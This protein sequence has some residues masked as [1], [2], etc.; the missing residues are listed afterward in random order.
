MSEQG[1]SN[2]QAFGAGIAA[3]IVVV[4]VGWKALN[5]HGNRSAPVGAVP[6]AAPVDLTTRDLVPAPTPVPVAAPEDASAA[7]APVAPGPVL[8]PEKTSSSAVRP[9]L[10]E[11]AEAKLTAKLS[12]EKTA[13]FTTARAEVK[14]AS[15]AP[16]AVAA[17]AAAPKPKL[18]ETKAAQSVASAV[19]YS[20]TSRAE[21]MGRAAGPVYNLQ[22]GGV[23]A[24]NQ[25]G[26]MDAAQTADQSVA[27]AR[28]VIEQSN[29]TVEEKT[30]AL[31][32]IDAAV[33][34]A[35]ANAAK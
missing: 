23:Q 18:D 30:K 22:A 16:V 10:R 31:A 32:Q 7:E 8:A 11:S 14:P 9:A 12:E 24:Q 6:A 5:W 13:A 3:F 19:Q 21:V 29:M 35:T 25:L 34:D 2:F 26:K 17:P 33:K 28:Q 15:P 27:A 4:A 1:K 20:A